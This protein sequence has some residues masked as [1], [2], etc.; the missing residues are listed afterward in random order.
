L[1]ESG[2]AL[3]VDEALDQHA[4]L[5]SI[6]DLPNGRASEHQRAPQPHPRSMP[7]VASEAGW[8][9]ARDDRRLDSIGILE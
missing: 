5:S 2:R 1:G 4:A 7:D 8:Q 3:N 9:T 6:G